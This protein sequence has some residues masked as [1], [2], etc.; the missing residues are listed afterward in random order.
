MR[1]RIVPMGLAWAQ[2][3]VCVYDRGRMLIKH[4]RSCS[5]FPNRRGIVSW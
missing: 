4:T 5:P 3:V 2:V 1:E